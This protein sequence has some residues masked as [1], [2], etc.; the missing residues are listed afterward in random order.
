MRS[1]NPNRH[2]RRQQ[3][4]LELLDRVLRIEQLDRLAQRSGHLTGLQRLRQQ[5]AN[6][7]NRRLVSI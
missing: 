3:P 7:R 2:V 4:R 1:G 5:P 6:R